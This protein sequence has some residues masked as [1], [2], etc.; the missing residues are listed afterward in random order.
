M[1]SGCVS[2]MVIGC[3]LKKMK[4]SFQINHDKRED[5]LNTINTLNYMN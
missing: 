5:I 4:K 1:I 2:S 3:D